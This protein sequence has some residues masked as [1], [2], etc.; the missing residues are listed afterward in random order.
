MTD[1]Q[2]KNEK[3]L[4]KLLNEKRESLRNFRF[5]IAGSKIRN[6]KEAKNTRRE[7]ARIETELHIRRT[8]T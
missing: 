1:I 8:Q 5:E 2:S 6:V 4:K 3:D 7:I